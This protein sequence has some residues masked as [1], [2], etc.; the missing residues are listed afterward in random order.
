[1]SSVYAD[2]CTYFNEE[3]LLDLI[4]NGHIFRFQTIYGP[5][6]YI[7][8]FFVSGFSLLGNLPTLSVP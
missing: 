2:S 3:T 8:G 7:F 6:T 4:F 1:M 5:I